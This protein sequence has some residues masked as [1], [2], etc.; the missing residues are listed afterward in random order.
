M[1]Y[2]DM[3]YTYPQLLF[4][5]HTIRIEDRLTNLRMFG[6]GYSLNRYHGFWCVFNE[7]APSS[8]KS[9]IRIIIGK[10]DKWQRQALH[11]RFIG[12]RVL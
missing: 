1:R 11:D 7:I 3:Y 5:P 12:T 10:S 4:K 2:K 9:L 6:N 8:I